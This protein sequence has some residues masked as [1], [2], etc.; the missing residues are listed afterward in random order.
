MNFGWDLANSWYGEETALHEI[1][2]TLGA[3]HEH[4]NPN[5]GIDWDEAEVYDFFQGPPNNW[6]RWKID[7]NILNKIAP[8]DVEG[9]N[10]D[11]DSIMHYQFQPDLIDGPPP[12][13]RKGIFPKPGLSK[14]DEEWVKKFYPLQNEEDY[15]ELNP[16]TSQRAVLNPGDQLDYIIR[17]D[18]SRKYKMQTFGDVDTLLVLFENSDSEPIYLAGDDDSGQNFNA[19]IEHRLIKGRSYIL[20]LRFYF[21]STGGETAVMLW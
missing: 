20:R 7:S 2:H 11:P 9:S 4:Q 17:P 19:S 15:I 13:D 21:S 10:W 16:F 12:Y 5:A 8:R 1:G 6:P 18:V 3:P 14:K